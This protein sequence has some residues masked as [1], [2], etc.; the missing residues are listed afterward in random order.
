MLLCR[1]RRNCIF[2]GQW[3]YLGLQVRLADLSRR[4]PGFHH[5]WNWLSNDSCYECLP[6]S[7]VS[8]RRSLGW[9]GRSS[10]SWTSL[11][12]QELCG[13]TPH[14]SPPCPRDEAPALGE[15]SEDPV[16]AARELK[17]T[18]ETST[19]GGFC[20]NYTLNHSVNYTFSTQ[21]KHPSVQPHG[22]QDRATMVNKNGRQAYRGGLCDAISSTRSVWCR[23]GWNQVWNSQSWIS[24][25][26][27]AGAPGSPWTWGRREGGVAGQQSEYYCECGIGK[28][29]GCCGH[30]CDTSE[31]LSHTSEMREKDRLLITITIA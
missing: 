4:F 19:S 2:K 24:S 5:V 29:W 25:P 22:T 7:S 15:P 30:K 20:L 26:P 3:F 1:R 31:R 23:C 21:Y 13:A 11:R 28:P 10:C 16:S 14:M 8:Q 18:E 12:Y 17:Q 6:P 9:P 27:S